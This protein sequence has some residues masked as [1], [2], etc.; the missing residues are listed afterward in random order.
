ME[1]EERFLLWLEEFIVMEASSILLLYRNVTCARECIKLFL[2]RSTCRSFQSI[3][4]SAEVG[5]SGTSRSSGHLEG[6]FL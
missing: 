3:S 5:D 2:S 4:G 6:V 1:W